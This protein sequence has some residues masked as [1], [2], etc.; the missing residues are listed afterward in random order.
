MDP[1][2]AK[3]MMR[4]LERNE[5]LVRRNPEGGFVSTIQFAGVI[6]AELVAATVTPVG[7][8][9]LAGIATVTLFRLFVFSPCAFTT[10]KV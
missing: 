4:D 9:P 3:P 1:L 7:T 5:D 6:V 8:P 2:H 10:V